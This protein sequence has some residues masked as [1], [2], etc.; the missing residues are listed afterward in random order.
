[1]KSASPDG[2][3]QGHGTGACLSIWKSNCWIVVVGLGPKQRARKVVAGGVI[4]LAK[5][6]STDVI[7]VWSWVHGCSSATQFIKKTTGAEFRRVLCVAY[8]YTTR[9]GVWEWQL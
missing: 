2:L 7:I 9:V 1:M 3:W 5:K 6:M 8:K 4:L